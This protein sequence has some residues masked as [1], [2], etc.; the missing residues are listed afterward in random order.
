MIKVTALSSGMIVRFTNCVI[1]VRG[2]FFW[3]NQPVNLI[4]DGC[5][6][7]VGNTTT[8]VNLDYSTGGIFGCNETYLLTQGD[9]QISN[10]VFM[11]T[12]TGAKNSTTPRTLFNVKTLYDVVLSNVTF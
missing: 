11:D 2:Q 4:F 12:A 5:T 6:F 10:S 1:D 3:S 8:L 9:I 7:L